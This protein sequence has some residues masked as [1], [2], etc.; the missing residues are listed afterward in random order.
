MRYSNAF[1]NLRLFTGVVA[2]MSSR[3]AVAE[4]I[5]TEPPRLQWQRFMSFVNITEEQRLSGLAAM[6]DVAYTNLGIYLRQRD[7]SMMAGA[8]PSLLFMSYELN[9]HI[10]HELIQ[11]VR[12]T[13]VIEVLSAM[14]IEEPNVQK[15]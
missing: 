1:F 15:R 5:E 10:R 3:L 2:R 11:L 8:L 6:Y 13:L 4:A 12:R 7:G 9:Q 14:P